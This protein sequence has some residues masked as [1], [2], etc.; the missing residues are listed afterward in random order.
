MADDA[1]VYTLDM[2]NGIVAICERKVD[3]FFSNFCYL[4]KKYLFMFSDIFF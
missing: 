2:N 3:D 1:N 4:E